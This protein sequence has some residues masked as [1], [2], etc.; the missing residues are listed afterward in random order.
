MVKKMKKEIDCA[1]EDVLHFIEESKPAKERNSF[2]RRQLSFLG[3]DVKK[4]CVP[5]NK[6]MHRLEAK[7]Q[8]RL[9][10]IQRRKDLGDYKR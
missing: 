4:P 7:K 8:R 9:A 2:K 6:G 5:F 1:L 10:V 3:A